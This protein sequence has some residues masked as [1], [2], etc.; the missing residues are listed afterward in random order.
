MDLSSTNVLFVPCFVGLGSPYWVPEARGTVFGLTRAT[1]AADLARAA[2]EGVAL[3]VVDLI[4]A[5]SNDLGKPLQELRVDGGM[6]RNDHFLQVQSDLLGLPVLRAGQSESTALG[7]AYLVAVQSGLTDEPRLR[8]LAAEAV[9]F[10]PMMP[11]KA[12]DAKRAQWR[13]AVMGFYA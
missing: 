3:Q 8:K 9:R 13:K 2:L 1:T 5:A 12:R 4:E 10:A 11:A 7:A 6:T